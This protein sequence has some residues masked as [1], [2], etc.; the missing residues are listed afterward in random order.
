[1]KK[2]RIHCIPG[3]SDG[4]SSAYNAGDLGSNPGSG[5]SPGEGNSNPL[6]GL[7]NPMDRGAWWA[8]VHGVAKSQTRLRDFTSLHCIRNKNSSNL[9]MRQVR[10]IHKELQ[11]ND[12]SANLII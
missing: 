10:G 6:H 4:K 5:R 11:K 3:S 1:M 8:I 2:P 12:S 7:E 9:G